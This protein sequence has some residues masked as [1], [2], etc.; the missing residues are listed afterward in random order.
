MTGSPSARERS[1]P[2]WSRWDLLKPSLPQPWNLT[3]HHT[4]SVDHIYHHQNINT[5]LQ[6]QLNMSRRTSP[7]TPRHGPYSVYTGATTSYFSPADGE[8]H[9][10]DET[11]YEHFDQRGRPMPPVMETAPFAFGAGGGRG[12][13]PFKATLLP[14]QG[15]A[16]GVEFVGDCP[17][18]GGSLSGD[19]PAS[20]VSLSGDLSVFGATLFPPQG[21]AFNAA[22]IPP[23]GRSTHGAAIPLR[24]PA[25]AA[26]EPTPEPQ[27]FSPAV[28]RRTSQ[29]SNSP[30]Q[31][32]ASP[33]AE[34]TTPA[35]DPAYTEAFRHV[36]TAFREA[37]E[38]YQ[39]AG[40]SPPPTVDP[41]HPRFHDAMYA[42][43]RLR[44]VSEN[45]PLAAEYRR[46]LREIMDDVVDTPATAPRSLEHAPVGR[47]ASRRGL[48]GRGT[49]RG[50][51]GLGPGADPLHRRTYICAVHD[52]LYAGGPRGICT[53]KTGF[54]W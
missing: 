33:D 11:G 7:H 27:A 37:W 21:P 48:M 14:P 4:T 44:H 10:P 30:D 24:A 51:L 19:R 25:S 13:P 6:T 40:R 15:P 54:T 45:H 29:A 52:T 22:A 50:H 5:A 20:G 41:R 1:L 17:A 28:S 34:P 16:F 43:E 12:R 36:G 42:A 49:M 26:E 35:N 32:A 39:Q 23:R 18:S 8:F 38:A 2:A 31:N 9:Y 47:G 46:V 3:P 53:C